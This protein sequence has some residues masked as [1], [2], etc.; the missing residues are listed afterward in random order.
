M[1]FPLS[2]HPHHFRS[3]EKQVRGSQDQI[4]LLLTTHSTDAEAVQLVDPMSWADVAR[5][6]HFSF[7]ATS[8]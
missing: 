5:M 4:N 1:A 2:L 6:S 7:L 3:F 8:S